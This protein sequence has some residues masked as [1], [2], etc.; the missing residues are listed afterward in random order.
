M[1]YAASRNLTKQGRGVGIVSAMAVSVAVH[2]L[3]VSAAFAMYAIEG[4]LFWDPIELLGASPPPG[5]DQRDGTRSR[6]FRT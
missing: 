1:F 3:L 6:R 5:F 2:R 4:L